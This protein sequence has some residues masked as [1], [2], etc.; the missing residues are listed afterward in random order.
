[1]HDNR[2]RIR[3][4]SGSVVSECRRSLSPGG[5]PDLADEG[6]TFRML[7]G[8]DSQV[9]IQVRPIQVMRRRSLNAHELD[10]WR[11]T[12]PR[13]LREGQEE[14]ALFEEEPEPVRGHV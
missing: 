11:I 1:M 7:D 14:L 9:H 13:E 2:K 8:L 5:R 12:E 4:R 6:K 3:W 10:D